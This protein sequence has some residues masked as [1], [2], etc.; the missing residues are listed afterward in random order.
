MTTRSAAIRLASGAVSTIKHLSDSYTITDPFGRV[1]RMLRPFGA[2]F[3]TGAWK[4]ANPISIFDN[5]EITLSGKN[6]AIAAGAGAR[7]LIRNSTSARQLGFREGDR[8][9]VRF[10]KI[11]GTVRSAELNVT[12]QATEAFALDGDVYT[13]S[14][15][16]PAGEPNIN[17]DI[18]NDDAG[19]TL[20]IEQPHW[21]VDREGEAAAA[22]AFGAG[23]YLEG[24]L[25][26]D[27]KTGFDIATGA[28]GFRE[29][30]G[31]TIGPGETRY[32]FVKVEKDADASPA[33]IYNLT[34][35]A[36]TYSG[37]TPL[38]SIPAAY[39]ED[40]VLVGILDAE[41]AGLTD[42]GLT[43]EIKIDNRD[44]SA[45]VAEDVVAERI[46]V[47]AEI[48]EVVADAVAPTFTP[49]KIRVEHHDVLTNINTP[50]FSGTGIEYLRE[51]LREYESG[52]YTNGGDGN[53]VGDFHLVERTGADAMK[54]L[55]EI[56]DE[57]VHDFAMRVR[58][59]SGTPTF[60][61]HAHGYH[62]RTDPARMW[63]DDVEVDDLTASITG[64]YDKFE[65]HDFTELYKFGDA[66]TTIANLTTKK[67]ITPGLRILDQEMTT[68]V[69]LDIEALYMAMFSVEN[70]VEPYH[71]N[72]FGPFFDD[73]TMPD[74]GGATYTRGNGVDATYP[75]ES[76]LRFTG[77]FGMQMDI[78]VVEGWEPGVSNSWV[79]NSDYKAYFSRKAITG[80]NGLAG[81][82]VTVPSGTTL[83][84]RTEFRPSTVAV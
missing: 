80:Q 79:L 18:E 44:S 42:V 24:N 49:D 70:D 48:P 16:V 58:Y 83:R 39:H 28:L 8:V 32:I 50:Y 14:F 72:N 27:N 3:P 19:A 1:H 12:G 36:A 54:V 5:G 69:D 64:W 17:F 38:V 51:Q 11:S 7:Y 35:R 21:K 84:M 33:T 57:S 60:V 61:G 56:S 73:I 13:A 65:R 23:E 41:T 2:I 66:A 6:A 59:A 10:A 30:Y 75:D 74:Q 20:E 78:E 25:W 40:G 47:F 82:P 31:F 22:A 55:H 45:H 4:R 77:P 9:I 81:S 71:G 43:L 53:T 34:A 63:L 37:S 29:Q 62:A 26:P 68:L 15:T 52:D 46:A 76:H 67:I